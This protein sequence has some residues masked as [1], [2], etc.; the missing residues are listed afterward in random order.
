MRTWNLLALSAATAIIAVAPAAADSKRDLD[1][2]LKDQAAKILDY[3]RSHNAKNIAVLKFLVRTGDGPWSDNAGPLNM[4]LARRLTVALILAAPDD[5]IGIISNANEVLAHSKANHLEEDGRMECFRSRGFVLAWGNPEI[6]VRPSLFITGTATLS[7]DLATTTIHLQAFGKDG[8]LDD[9]LG[10]FTVKTSARTLID[11]G[12]SYLM[13]P[14]TNPDLFNG[15]RGGDDSELDQ[16]AV[17]ATKKFSAD[18]RNDTLSSFDQDSPIRVLIYYGDEAIPIK[19]GAVREPKQTDKVWFKL[20]NMTDETYGV[21]L[22]VNGVNTIFKERFADR[23]CHKWILKPHESVTIRGFQTKLDKREDFTVLPPE[24]SKANEIQYGEFA[25]TF[26]VSVFHSRNGKPAAQAPAPPP[27]PTPPAPPPPAP[28]EDQQVVAAI[29]RGT[30]KTE[31]I[32]PG[33]LK[34]LQAQLRTRVQT[35]ENGRGLIESDPSNPT[36]HLVQ[37]IDFTADPG[38]PIMSYKIQYYQRAAGK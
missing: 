12:H 20:D 9:S 21:V 14:K 30:I 19:D 10:D 31:G 23:D 32:Q 13:T 26:Q 8:K 3:A 11:T 35:S 33:D 24:K 17:E 34:S 6:P 2:A 22:K 16:P 28:T 4:D 38:I 18:L 36:S 15:S 25:G 27:M 7:K 29:S 37:K 1:S 5:R